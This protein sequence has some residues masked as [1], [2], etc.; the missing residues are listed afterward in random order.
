MPFTAQK[1][2]REILSTSKLLKIQIAWMPW[3]IKSNAKQKLDITSRSAFETLKNGY[4][5][6]KDCF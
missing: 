3:H 2:P 1:A 6:V 4:L 5:K